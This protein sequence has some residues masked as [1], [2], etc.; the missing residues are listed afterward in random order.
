MYAVFFVIIIF[1]LCGLFLHFSYNYYVYFIILVVGS[2]QK[3]KKKEIAKET[4]NLTFSTD[5]R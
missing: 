2:E 5:L 3:E 1:A 4:Y